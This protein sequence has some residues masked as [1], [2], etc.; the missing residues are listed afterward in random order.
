MFGP[1]PY[2]QLRI[3]LLNLYH[4]KE[5]NNMAKFAG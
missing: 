4:N 5:V 3:F 2:L 1:L